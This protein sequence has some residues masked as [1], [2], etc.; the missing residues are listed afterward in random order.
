MYTLPTSNYLMRNL[1]ANKL[2]GWQ[3]VHV[4]PNDHRRRVLQELKNLGVSKYGLLMTESQYLPSIIHADEQLC[5]VV[6]GH[7]DAG[8]AMLVATDRR[9]I[10]LDKKPLFVDQDDIDYGVVAGVS[11]GHAGFASTVTLHTRI[12]DYAIRTLSIKSAD[13]FV[14][15]IENRIEHPAR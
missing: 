3:P 2:R 9:V 8:F 14:R 13:G 6:Y 15:Y 10:F 4:D 12:K 1:Q 11:H 7:H 5:G